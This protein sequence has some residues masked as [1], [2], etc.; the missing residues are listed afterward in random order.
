[1]SVSPSQEKYTYE[2]YLQWNGEPRYELIDGLPYG[3][4]APTRRHQQ[5]VGRIFN[6]IFNFL[7][8]HPCEVYVAPFS[9]YLESSEAGDTVLE[10]DITVICDPNKLDERGCKGAPDFIIEVLSPSTARNDQ[11]VKFNKYLKTG[12]Q[13]YWIVNPE[14][15]MI[16]TCLLNEGKYFLT[17][18]GEENTIN[19]FVLE[20][21]TLDLATIFAS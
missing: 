17:P 1:M 7:N 9:V 16:Q 11:L 18:Y 15:N 13:E 19:S 3:M 6:Q 14:T 2:D 8:H 5:I 12:V 10:P 21:L 20:G 4:A